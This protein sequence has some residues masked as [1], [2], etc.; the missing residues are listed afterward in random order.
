[1]NSGSRHAGNGADQNADDSTSSQPAGR[2]AA[3]IAASAGPRS[4]F[5]VLRLRAGPWARL[6][7]ISASF[8]IA[9]SSSGIRRP[10]GKSRW[11]CSSSSWVPT[12]LIRPSSM[13]DDLVGVHAREATRWAMMILVVSGRSP[14]GTPCGSARR[15]RYPRRWWSRPGS[16]PWAFSAGPGRCTGAASG[17]RIRWCRPARC[18]CRTRPGSRWIKPS[19]C[20]SLQAW[21]ISSSVAFSLPQ[22]RFSLMVPENSS[23]FCSTMA[24]CVAQGCPDRSRARPRRRPARCPRSRRTAGGS[25]APG[26]TWRSRC[27]PGCRWSRRCGCAG[28]HRSSTGFSELAVVA[29]DHVVE[30]DGAVLHFGDGVFRADDVALLVQHLERCA[31][32]K[33]GR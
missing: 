7:F 21:R 14:S 33:P 6:A 5:Q 24:T 9:S 8:C 28:P 2:V 1:M 10:R 23:F 30:V 3:H 27:R 22:R 12:P 19:A 20:A 25:A 17:R 31:R 16:G 13:H 4:A 18:R 15:S 32:R 29:E 11:S 26:W